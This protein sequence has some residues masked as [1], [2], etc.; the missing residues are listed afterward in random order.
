MM[1]I[2]KNIIFEFAAL[3][4]LATSI[5]A[6]GPQKCIPESLIG[7]KENVARIDSTVNAIYGWEPRD[8]T[9]DASVDTLVE[10]VM[11]EYEAERPNSALGA[12]LATG[13]EQSAYDEARVTWAE[14]KRL[15]NQEKYEEALDYYFADKPNGNGS[16]SGDF[17][18]FLKHSSPRFF[19]FSEVL[20][21]M[22]LEYKGV[23]FARK[24]YIDLLK[25][26]KALEDTSIAIQADGN[27]YIPEVYPYLI[28]E[29]GLALTADGK[30]DEALE[31]ADD[32]IN[33]VYQTSG[34]TLYANFVGTQYAAKLY[35][36]LDD[37][38]NAI[39]IWEDFKRFLDDTTDDYP[40]EIYEEVQAHIQEQIDQ[41]Q[42]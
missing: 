3:T 39:G 4:A 38:K 34:E 7:I 2:M 11:K 25:L 10:N 6:C 13:L 16:N 28:K 21:P 20:F 18:L 33:I 41:I 1:I 5:I 19:F 9:H 29:L 40:A 15:C 24:K 12:N 32:L 36:Y 26:E 8:S 30:L 27:G 23:E 42:K 22:M 37:K 35:L 14:F 17:L 31:L